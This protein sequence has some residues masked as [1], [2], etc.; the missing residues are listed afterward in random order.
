MPTFPATL[1]ATLT[2]TVPSALILD[3]NTIWLSK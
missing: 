3:L 2:L 1:T